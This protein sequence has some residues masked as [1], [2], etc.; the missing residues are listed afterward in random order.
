MSAALA[1][2]I[3]LRSDG[4]EW[5][6]RLD[7]YEEAVDCVCP[8]CEESWRVYLQPHQMLRLELFRTAGG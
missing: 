2:P 8:R 4:I 7:F 5:E 1:C 3:C 6:E